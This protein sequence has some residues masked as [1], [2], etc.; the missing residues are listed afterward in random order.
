MPPRY[1]REEWLHEQYHER[2]K[3]QKELADACDVSPRTIREWMNRHD[4]ET[5]TLEGENH[6]LYGKERDEAVKERISETMEGRDPSEETR[7]RMSETQTGTELPDER[8]RK[9][10]EALRD[11]EKSEET[12]RRM[13]ESR[14]GSDNPHWKGGTQSELWTRLV[15][16]TRCRTGA[17][18]GM[19]ELWNR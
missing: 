10:A 19:P 6:P 7:R 2:G 1:Q 17:R 3:T 11:R 15:S 16:G 18:R 9:I 13:S 12:R 8:K 4:I 5:R 14:L